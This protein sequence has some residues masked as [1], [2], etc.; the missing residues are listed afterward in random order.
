MAAP[1]AGIYQCTETKPPSMNPNRIRKV[2]AASDEGAQVPPPILTAT[3]RQARTERPFEGTH[4][5]H[6]RDE[7]T[8]PPLRVSG[9]AIQQPV[10]VQRKSKSQRG[11]GGLSEGSRRIKNSSPPFTSHW[12]TVLSPLTVASCSPSGLK[13]ARITVCS[14]PTRRRTSCSSV[15]EYRVTFD[16]PRPTCAIHFPSGLSVAHV[17]LSGDSGNARTSVGGAVA[18]TFSGLCGSVGRSGKPA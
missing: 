6:R 5:S 14:C 12:R 8:E 18:R 3:P 2:A 15:V 10:G 17:R 11:A 4:P 1:A 16:A 13:M 9:T 7:A